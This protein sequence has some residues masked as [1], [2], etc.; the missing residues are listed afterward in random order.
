MNMHREALDYQ[1]RPPLPE[2]QLRDLLNRMADWLF[3]SASA[4]DWD[5]ASWLAA[6]WLAYHQKAMTWLAAAVRDAGI[7]L[8]EE[9][10]GALFRLEAQSRRR[11]QK[12]LSTAAEIAD[13]MREQDI[14]VLPL[15]GAVLALRHYAAPTDRPLMDLDLL[16]RPQDYAAAKSVMYAQGF[17]MYNESAKDIALYRGRRT[18]NVWSPDH[19]EL[20]DLHQ[21]VD[22]R[23]DNGLTYDLSGVLWEGA[24]EHALDGGRFLLPGTAALLTHLCAHAGA[25]WLVRRGSIMQIFDVSRAAAFMQPGDWEQLI[26]GLGAGK[27]RLVYP[28]LSIAARLA[29]AP[30]P[31]EVLDELRR[32]CPAALL[33]WTGRQ[34]WAALSPFSGQ[35]RR[36]KREITRLLAGSRREAIG[37][38]L[39]FFFPRRH[40]LHHLRENLEDSPF[41]S[42]HY[43]RLIRSPFWPLA[44]LLINGSR[45]RRSVAGRLR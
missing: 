15:K 31:P 37:M 14:P 17:E 24:E 41:W 10:A 34:D 18:D 26:S 23:L 38:S 28:V 45:L 42:R 44:Y 2:S 5:R 16:V 4:P 21:L 33:D 1:S 3:A 30:V 7:D 36:S 32:A 25:D 27:A 39:R 35:P 13:A 20:V 19:W 11:T 9:P 43:S 6:A 8:P 29:S 12:M 22:Q 40:D